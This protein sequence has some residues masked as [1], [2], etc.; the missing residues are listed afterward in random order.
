MHG[1]DITSD[2][3][4]LLYQDHSSDTSDTAEDQMGIEESG[5]YLK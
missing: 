5:K 2:S 1:D 3:A 4:F